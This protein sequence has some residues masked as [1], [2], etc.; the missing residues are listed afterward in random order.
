MDQI[1][2]EKI[3][4]AI[5]ILQKQLGTSEA[6]VHQADRLP[7][8]WKVHRAHARAKIKAGTPVTEFP[9][10]HPSHAAAKGLI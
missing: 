4:N 5:Q 6:E 3:R 9:E 8:H 7:L 1:L 10:Q 2:K